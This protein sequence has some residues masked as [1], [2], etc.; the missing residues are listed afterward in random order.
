MLVELSKPA[1][2]LLALLARVLIV[3]LAILWFAILFCF[4]IGVPVAWSADYAKLFTILAVLTVAAVVFGLRRHPSATESLL[5]GRPR[6]GR[7]SWFLLAAAALGQLSGMWL[8]RVGESQAGGWSMLL[9]TVIA[10]FE[11]SSIIGDL[12]LEADAG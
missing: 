6:I 11:I 9:S 5:S 3:P 4:G 2:F 1:I 8:T 12:L 7:L 10:L